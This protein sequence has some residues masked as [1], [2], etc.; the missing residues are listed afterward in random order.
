MAMAHRRSL[1]IP[2]AGL[3]SANDAL[4]EFLLNDEDVIH[5]SVVLLSPEMAC[6]GA[7][8]QL[9]GD[10][11]TASEASNAAFDHVTH[12]K[13]APHL[14]YIGR[15]ALVSEAGITRDDEQ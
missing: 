14:T 13:L 8:D 9:A 7:V 4:G 1:G 2:D 15:P 12:A 5:G 10:L 3:D 6:R 11:D